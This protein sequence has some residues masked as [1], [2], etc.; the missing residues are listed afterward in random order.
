M[1]QTFSFPRFARLNRWFW[2]AKSRTYLI[3]SLVLLVL[4]LLILSPVLNTDNEFSL[5]IQR[6]NLVYFMIISLLL[7]GSIGSDVFSAL[8]RQES[9][10]SYLM[11]PASRAEKFWLGVL[12]CVVAM[13]MFGVIYFGYE[14]IVFNIANSHLPPKE[15]EK[16]VSS[17]IFHTSS[18][19]EDK[20]LPVLITYL[21]LLILVAA[22]LG[23]FF[24]RRGVFVRNVGFALMVT[25]GS[26]M[27]YKWIISWQFG[28]AN[29]GTSLPF[30][31][32][33]INVKNG[34]SHQL[35][36]PSWVYFG[37]YVGTLLALWVI[38]RIRFNEIER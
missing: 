34:L 1:N 32:I 16:Y 11:I 10:I 27:L 19:T 31:P 7:A 13:L 29:T 37:A 21:L 15:T 18:I 36:L 2:A 4:S 14:A 30:L 20:D 22:I 5:S 24:F 33:S 12:Y 25:L 9:A 8:F 3:A 26:V 38:A 6:G 23:S 17:L 28:S 35:S